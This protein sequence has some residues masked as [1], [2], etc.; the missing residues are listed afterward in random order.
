MRTLGS[1]VE[2]ERGSVFGGVVAENANGKD[3]SIPDEGAVCDVEG[4]WTAAALRMALSGCAVGSTICDV[5]LKKRARMG[6]RKVGGNLVTGVRNSRTERRSA[7]L[8]IDCVVTKLGKLLVDN[9]LSAPSTANFRLPK[10]NCR[11]FGPVRTKCGSALFTNT[12]CM[13]QASICTDHH[14][15]LDG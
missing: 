12:N 8:M 6:S 13:L 10:Q 11:R 4:A 9:V 1:R 2:G 3:S 14:Y 5:W 7:L 15:H